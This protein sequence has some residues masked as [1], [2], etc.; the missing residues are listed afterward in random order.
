MSPFY[1]YGS[2]FSRLLFCFYLEDRDL[3]SRFENFFFRQWAKLWCI[4]EVR[5]QNQEAAVKP[6]SSD[7]NPVQIMFLGISQPELIFR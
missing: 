5:P 2:T 7:Q 3:C 1:G 6:R 4:K